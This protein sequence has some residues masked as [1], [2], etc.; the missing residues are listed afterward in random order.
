MSRE[1]R[2]F[3]VCEVDRRGKILARASDSQVPH[4]VAIET[5]KQLTKRYAAIAVSSYEY[6]MK[7]RKSE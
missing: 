1:P 6:A 3:Y 4:H 7:R 2:L 5:A